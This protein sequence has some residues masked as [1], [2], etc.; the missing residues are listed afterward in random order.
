[1]VSQLSFTFE[2]KNYQDSKINSMA[3]NNSLNATQIISPENYIVP[4]NL[5]YFLLE[6][7]AATPIQ[8]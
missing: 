6:N 7:Q 3:T 1:M 5:L 8:K 2:N 4:H